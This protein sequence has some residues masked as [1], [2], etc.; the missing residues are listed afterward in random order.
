MFYYYSGLLVWFGIVFGYVYVSGFVLYLLIPYDLD[1]NERNKRDW[2]YTTWLIALPAIIGISPKYKP[3]SGTIRMFYSCV[4][5]CAMILFQLAFSRIYEFLHLD[6]PRHQ[7]SSFREIVENN[8]HL[9]GSQEA[10]NILSDNEK[11]WLSNERSLSPSII[12][13]LFNS[14]VRQKFHRLRQYER[15]H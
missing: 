1:Y 12:S 5:I 11:V 14:T 3:V 8:F 9:M 7:V 2:H 6:I 15:M 10:F 4:L 13:I